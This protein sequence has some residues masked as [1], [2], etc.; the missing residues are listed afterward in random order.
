MKFAKV[1]QAWK[2]KLCSI[3]KTHFGSLADPHLI[4]MAWLQCIWSPPHP[5]W[6]YTSTKPPNMPLNL[7]VVGTGQQAVCPSLA[8]AAIS[9]S[10]WNWQGRGQW[11]G[12]TVHSI[13]SLEMSAAGNVRLPRGTARGPHRE[14]CGILD[15]VHNRRVWVI[16]KEFFSWVNDGR[17]SKYA[18]YFCLFC[19]LR[20]S[21]PM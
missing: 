16:F 4:L 10:Q 2:G 18:S 20:Q 13:L 17:M 11:L 19:I 12:S 1:Y 3:F 14:W 21:L 8:Q 15:L 9:P 5:R 7:L 6:V